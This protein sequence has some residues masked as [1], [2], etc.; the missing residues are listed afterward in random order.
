MKTDDHTNPDPI[1]PTLRVLVGQPLWGS[2]RAADMEMFAFGQ[3][4]EDR[5]LQG[6][7]MYRGEFA[8]H[9]QCAWRFRR[10]TQIL[11]GSR[12][13]YDP[14]DSGSEPQSLEDFDWDEQGINRRDRLLHQL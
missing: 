13:V 11:V 4:I 10:G 5:G 1:E 8:L 12:D 7:R 9:V 6:Q 2:K 3:R 14:F